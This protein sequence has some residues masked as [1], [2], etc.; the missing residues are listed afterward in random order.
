[1]YYSYKYIRYKLR[2]G[3]LLAFLIRSWLLYLHALN[4]TT[5]S[6]DVIKR[7]LTDE[8]DYYLDEMK[9]HRLRMR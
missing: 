2:L 7:L 5:I 4:A 1:M 8:N 6:G 3:L 9:S